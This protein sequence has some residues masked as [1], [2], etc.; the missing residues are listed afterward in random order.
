MPSNKPTIQ[1]EADVKMEAIALSD[2]IELANDSVGTRLKRARED[3]NF[4]QEEAAVHLDKTRPVISHMETGKRNPTMDELIVLSAVYDVSIVW[5]MKGEK[6][7][8]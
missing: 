8:G 5:L 4:T 7:D 1:I 3:A 6:E 2:L